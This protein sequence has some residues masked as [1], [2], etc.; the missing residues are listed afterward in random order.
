MVQPR[1]AA[2]TCGLGEAKAC[3]DGSGQ[4]WEA[5]TLDLSPS[6]FEW[7]DQSSVCACLSM[8]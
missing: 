2:A 6:G 4:R 8:L 5:V 7:R 1:R 3:G